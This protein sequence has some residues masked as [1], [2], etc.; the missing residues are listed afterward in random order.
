MHFKSQPGKN[1]S[2][3]AIL[4]PKNF[5]SATQMGLQ[6]IKERKVRLRS[7]T[8]SNAEESNVLESLHGIFKMS[9]LCWPS[10]EDL[11]INSPE[12]AA[13]R[14]RSLERP[15][16]SDITPLPDLPSLEAGEAPMEDGEL[17]RAAEEIL[18]H[19]KEALSCEE[20]SVALQP[21]AATQIWKNFCRA[22]MDHTETYMSSRVAEANKFVQ[23]REQELV[24][25]VD[26]ALE[27]HASRL[28]VSQTF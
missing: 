20:A 15:S 17:A 21:G 23:S 9:R 1:N 8:D 22:W 5:L 25:E 27:L 7:S 16:L 13:A 24:A 10:R 18:E 28:Q 19:L 2:L 4:R 11:K 3:A 12:R 14:R 26:L 6:M